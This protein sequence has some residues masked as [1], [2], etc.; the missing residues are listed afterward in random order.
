MW[1]TSLDTLEVIKRGQA[2]NLTD[3]LNTVDT[4]GS[5]K[6]THEEEADGTIPFLDTLIER[7]GEGGVKLKVYRKKTHTNQYL[8]FHSHHP[9][10][11]KLGVVRT[12]IDRCEGIVTEEEDKQ[13]ERTTIK[14]ALGVCGYPA[15]TMRT[16][17]NQLERK[18]ERKTKKKEQ[19]QEKSRGMVILPYVKDLSEKISRIL[20]KWK[21]SAPMK[22]HTTLRNLLLH[23]KDKLDPREGVYKIDCKNC[24]RCYI[25]ET[26]RKLGVRLKEH[27]EEVE[28]LDKGR[29]FT[30]DSK[31]Q[32]HRERSKSAIADHVT[33]DNHVID[34]DSAKLVQREGDWLVRG[35][36]EAITIRK[37]PRNMNRD[38]GRYQLSHLYDDL[39]VPTTRD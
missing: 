20:K 11:H 1:K 24:D 29:S 15:W 26:K 30:R 9:L 36:K 14:D 7:K 27:R 34:W 16:V 17:Q 4:T 10:H 33:Q 19:D 32:A 12:L 25:G 21:I 22:P 6:F 37:N 3:H 18:E 8:S 31:K 28:K 23:P 35:I 5:I 2:S 13:A 38:E 39:L